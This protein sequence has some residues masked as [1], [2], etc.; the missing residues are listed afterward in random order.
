MVK[1]KRVSDLGSCNLDNLLSNPDSQAILEILRK[2]GDFNILMGHALRAKKVSRLLNELELKG[3]EFEK[4]W[5]SVYNFSKNTCGCSVCHE[6]I[7]EVIQLPN[8]QPMISQTHSLFDSA[9]KAMQEHENSE[10]HENVLHKLGMR[11]KRKR[12]LNEETEV[13][14]RKRRK[15][16]KTISSGVCIYCGFHSEINVDL[17]EKTFPNKRTDFCTAFARLGDQV[18]GCHLAQNCGPRL[19]DDQLEIQL[20]QFT[21]TDFNLVELMSMFNCRP[22]GVWEALGIHV[23]AEQLLGGKFTLPSP[24][25]N[26]SSETPSQEPRPEESVNLSAQENT[27]SDNESDGEATVPDPPPEPETQPDPEGRINHDEIPDRRWLWK[28][29]FHVGFETRHGWR[30]IWS[31][32]KYQKLLRLMLETQQPATPDD[33]VS[34]QKEILQWAHRLLIEHTLDGE[35]EDEWVEFHRL[36]LEQ[37]RTWINMRVPPNIWVNHSVSVWWSSTGKWNRGR[38]QSIVHNE[39]DSELNVDYGCDYD[40]WLKLSDTVLK[41]TDFQ[42]EEWWIDQTFDVKWDGEHEWYTARVDSVKDYCVSLCYTDGSKEEINVNDVQCF[43]FAEDRSEIGQVHE[44]IS[45]LIEAILNNSSLPILLSDSDQQEQPPDE[46]LDPRSPPL[47]DK[48]YIGETKMA[49]WAKTFRKESIRFE[50][51][52]KKKRHGKK[53]QKILVASKITCL[54][55]K[56]VNEDVRFARGT[57]SNGSSALAIRNHCFPQPSFTFRNHAENLLIWKKQGKAGGNNPQF[58]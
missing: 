36:C 20:N 21:F 10:V 50:P 44:N 26:Q 18:L 25:L 6:Q 12:K 3:E 8:P 57:L 37:V 47:E 32:E 53:G 16:S 5:W 1:R 51:I 56:S 55:C 17:V 46:I 29:I 42:P 15:I 13:Q 45:K 39:N 43:Y 52:D 34:K 22:E 23:A 14:P 11:T 49:D 38:I 40:E 58:L 48:N 31:K 30:L 9:A 41:F 4:F 2:G 35:L 7:D 27:E 54:A 24:G 19:R 33:S 28:A